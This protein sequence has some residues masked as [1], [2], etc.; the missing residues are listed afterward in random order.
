V[1]PGA[2]DAR[3]E[4]PG[5]NAMANHGYLPHNGV[6]TIQQ[7]VTGTAQVFGMATVGPN[8]DSSHVGCA[9]LT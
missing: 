1:A 7:F 9:Q 5:L 6:A 2:G 3:G 8:I 4:C